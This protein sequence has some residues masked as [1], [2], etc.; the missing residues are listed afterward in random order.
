MRTVYSD[1]TFF[2]SSTFIRQV[3]YIANKSS[4]HRFHEP[5]VTGYAHYAD[6]PLQ[7]DLGLVIKDTEF[8]QH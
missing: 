6:Y 4:Q 8:Y 1:P 5:I 7:F 2:Y 3:T